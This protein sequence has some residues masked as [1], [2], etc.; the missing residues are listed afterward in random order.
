MSGIL[1]IPSIDILNGKTVRVVKG[2]PE[3]GSKNYGDDPVEM[4]LIWRA[5]NAKMLHI[6]DFD[7][8]HQHSK[9]NLEIVKEIC[10]AVIIP[11][12]F[13]GG[14]NSIEDA[15]KVFDAGVFRLVI[16]SLAF[17]S[18]ETFKKLIEIYGSQKI[19]AAIDVKDNEVVVH[20]RSQKTGISPLEYA[21]RLI[22]L[23]AERLIITDVNRNGM[24]V[25]PNI[26]LTVSI[27]KAL[28]VKVTHSGGITGYEDLKKLLPYSSIGIDSVI[29]GRAFYENKFPCQKIWRIAE[30]GIFN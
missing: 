1:I 13:G 9:K 6:V 10:S 25:G 3:I 26:D 21:K 22:D 30:E 12:E 14:I 18:P 28:N 2:V 4:A 16:G 8:S 11:V 24:L 29:I 5:E 19:T 7:F 20:G 17:D 15:E 23:G 27:A